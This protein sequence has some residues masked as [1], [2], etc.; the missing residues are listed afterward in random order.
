MPTPFETGRAGLAPDAIA[1]DG[2]EV[3]VLASLSRGAVAEFRLAP[4]ATGRAVAHR[5]VEEIW[6]F[7]KG[8]G[9]LWRK[10]GDVEEVTEVAPG[11]AVSLPVGTRFQLRS[12]SEEP[13]VAIAATLP[14]W[15]GEEEAILV[16]GIWSPTV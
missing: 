13:L 6:Y 1:P 15:P 12:D 14:P 9:R 11:T 8:K 4:M 2:L 5:T 3:R 16:A 7:T 10:L